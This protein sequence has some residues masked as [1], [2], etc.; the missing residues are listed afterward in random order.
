MM[1]MNSE[2]PSTD[3]FEDILEMITTGKAAQREVT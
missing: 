1:R 3:H 2:Q